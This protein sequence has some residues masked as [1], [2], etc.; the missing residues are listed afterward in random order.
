MPEQPRAQLHVDAVRGMREQVRAKNP[1][2]GL[3]YRDGGEADDQHVEG[4]ER[5]VHQH[6]VD[7]HLEE[8][9]RDERKQLQEE[10]R[11]QDFPQQPPVFVDG[12]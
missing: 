12:A 9:R 8:Q 6:L 2:D 11:N 1:E 7:D 10:R 4:A 5:T 3:E